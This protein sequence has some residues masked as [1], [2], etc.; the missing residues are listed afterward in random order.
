MLTLR[1]G[2]NGN[3]RWLVLCTVQKRKRRNGPRGDGETRLNDR[4]S[5]NDFPRAIGFGGSFSLNE[6]TSFSF[7]CR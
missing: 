3:Q 2:K 7:R 6:W 4:R 1:A 5:R